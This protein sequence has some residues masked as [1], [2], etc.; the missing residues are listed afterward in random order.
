MLSWHYLTNGLDPMVAAYLFQSRV[1]ADF[2]KAC[3]Y[4]AAGII[5]LFAF[6][7]LLLAKLGPGHLCKLRDSARVIFVTHIAFFAIFLATYV[8]YSI[9]MV[10]I[11]FTTGGLAHLRQSSTYLSVAYSL[12]F[13]LIMYGAEGSFRAVSRINVFLIIHHLMFCSLV[14]LA[15]E[16]KSPF[17]LKLDLIVSC[18]AT[19]EV[20]LYAA[21]IVRKT[22]AHTI[23]VKAIMAAGLGF[24]GFT[25]LLQ[26]VLL[27]GLF[28][29]GYSYQKETSKGLALW[30]TSL[31]MSALLV[32][33]QCYTFV[34][35]GAIW[36]RLGQSI[37][38]PEL[39]L[40][41]SWSAAQRRINSS[42]SLPLT[43]SC[44]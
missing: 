32:A 2:F 36:K 42:V 9:A 24:Y 15:F 27:I 8:P 28:A 35:Y 29:G 13:Q 1:L 25:R 31:V 34:I 22:H 14:M 43:V 3:Y 7:N 17:V 19:Y 10:R 40:K 37:T 39:D 38:K 20:L 26:L 41:T 44:V 12:A 16:A 18:F 5:L 21:L 23:V 6:T 30:W 11:L 4:C 33:L